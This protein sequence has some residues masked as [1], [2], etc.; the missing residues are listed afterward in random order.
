MV[1]PLLDWI[2]KKSLNECPSLCIFFTLC[3]KFMVTHTSF[4]NQYVGEKISKLSHWVIYCLYKVSITLFTRARHETELCLE[5][6][7]LYLR[8]NQILHTNEEAT[9]ALC[10]NSSSK[11]AIEI[12]KNDKKNVSAGFSNKAEWKR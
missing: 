3:N 1:E 12:T 11:S 10:D 2:L 4:P 8:F 6:A 5:D 9:S 7:I